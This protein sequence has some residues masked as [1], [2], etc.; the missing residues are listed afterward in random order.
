VCGSE[1]A[2]SIKY[3]HVLELSS[4]I[5]FVSECNDYH[6]ASSLT[7]LACLPGRYL[8]RC[9]VYIIFTH[10]TVII[11]TNLHIMYYGCCQSRLFDI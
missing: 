5:Q 11:F 2:G 1:P 4:N 8:G 9:Q 10:Y 7:K 6:G 3:G